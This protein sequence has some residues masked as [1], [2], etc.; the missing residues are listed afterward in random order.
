[1]PKKL[2]NWTFRDIVGF[3]KARGFGLHRVRGSEH[4]YKGIYGGE[5]RLVSVPFHGQKPIKP[6]TF[7]SIIAQS[8]ISQDEW[9]AD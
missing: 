6:G 9:R 1:M 7:K 5:Q 2:S 3:L 8:G 4:F